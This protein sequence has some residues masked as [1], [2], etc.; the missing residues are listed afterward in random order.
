[1]KTRDDV[2]TV[3]E[4]GKPEA[5]IDCFIGEYLEAKALQPYLD[6]ETEYQA[7]SECLPVVEEVLAEDGTVLVPYFDPNLECMI[8][9]HALIEQFPYLGYEDRVR[10]PLV[11]DVVEG[12]ELKRAW[13]KRQFQGQAKVLIVDSMSGFPMDA[14]REDIDNLRNL[15]EVLEAIGETTAEIRDANNEF[16]VMTLGDIRNLRMEMTQA[17]LA[18]Y[19]AKWQAEQELDAA[20]DWRAV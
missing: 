1:M 12:K 4:L 13:I 11:L 18:L 14:R 8:K 9:W 5:V 3:I 16:H 20:T 19:Q 17:G 15:V 2:L 6:A 10:P 7:L